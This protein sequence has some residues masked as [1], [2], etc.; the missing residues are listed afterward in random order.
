MELRMVSWNLHGA[1]LWNEL[2]G[3]VVDLA[4]LQEARFPPEGFLHEVIP[5]HPAWQID[6][7]EQRPSAA[8]VALLSDRVRLAGQLRVLPLGYAGWDEMAVSR[9]GT[10]AAASVQAVEGGEPIT[11]VSVYAPWERPVPSGSSAWI[12]ADASAHRIISDISALIGH[13]TDHR[14]IVAGDWNLL[15]GYGESGD[16]YW[17]GR[18]GTVFDRMEALGLS[19]VGPQFNKEMP[20]GRQAAPAR[21]ELPEGSLDLPTFR[22][23]GDPASATRQLDFVFASKGIADQVTATARNLPENWGPSDHCRIDI[24]V[25]L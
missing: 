16:P 25:A 21:P 2:A 9:P 22:G 3:D 7:W 14:I 4:L 11:V 19:F 15:H 1:A 13:P 10:I 12:Y 24:T 17:K 23:N 20:V 5:G 6:G 8:A 18:Y